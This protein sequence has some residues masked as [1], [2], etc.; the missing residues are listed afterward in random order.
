MKMTFTLEVEYDLT[1]DGKPRSHKE[2]EALTEHLFNVTRT[3]LVQTAARC[4]MVT[5][6]RACNSAEPWNHEGPSCPL[7][8]H[9][10]DGYYVQVGRCTHDH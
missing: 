9:E 8:D 1:A 6:V 7:H 3:L 4:P 10:T 5:D 2:R